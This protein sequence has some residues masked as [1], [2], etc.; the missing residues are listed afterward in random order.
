LLKKITGWKWR[1]TKK[2]SVPDGNE[3]S[4]KVIPSKSVRI[5]SK[6]IAPGFY[7]IN[8]W[9]VGKREDGIWYALAPGNSDTDLFAD[10]YKMA[11]EIVIKRIRGIKESCCGVVCDMEIITEEKLTKQWVAG[12]RKWWK[13]WVGDAK[14]ISKLR[15]KKNYNRVMKYLSSGESMINRLKDN[16][17]YK[18]GL[19]VSPGML[20][21]GN[22]E[23]DI[24]KFK[25]A[26]FTKPKID[27][28]YMFDDALKKI[29]DI[30]L[31]FKLWY[32]AVYDPK[33]MAYVG[34]GARARDTTGGKLTT[35]DQYIKHIPDAIR[36]LD[37]VVSG[38]I[39]RRLS[40][41]VSVDTDEFGHDDPSESEFFIGK[42]K[43]VVDP[44]KR[45]VQSIVKQGAYLIHPSY[46][47]RYVEQIQ[48]AK[49]MIDRAGFG[50]MWY[51]NMFIRSELSAR[52]GVRVGVGTYSEGAHYNIEKDHVV[53]FG[54]PN[55]K[56]HAII[57]HELGHRWYFKFMNKKER[58]GFDSY[59]GGYPVGKTIPAPVAVKPGKVRAVS[60]Y[61]G[62]VPYEDFAE[63]FMWYVLGRK[64]TRDQRERFKEFALKGGKIRR[65]EDIFNLRDQL[66]EG[67]SKF[68]PDRLVRGMQG[69]W[70][71]WRRKWKKMGLKETGR[72]YKDADTFERYGTKMFQEASQMFQKLDMHLRNEHGYWPPKYDD[73]PKRREEPDRR[74]MLTYELAE[75]NRYFSTGYIVPFRDIVNSVESGD[76]TIKQAGLKVWKEATDIHDYYVRDF[77]GGLKRSK[78]DPDKR[79]SF[80]RLD[81]KVDIGKVKFVF[82]F[83]TED[84]IIKRD[85]AF[86]KFKP[87]DVTKNIIRAAD[88]A[89]ALMKKSGFGFMWKG[90]VWV[91]P[92][93]A[94]YPDIFGRG[95][96]AAGENTVGWYSSKTDQIVLYPTAY[97]SDYYAP[98]SDQIAR[99]LVHE[100]AHRY[101]FKHLSSA[102]RAQF[103]KWFLSVDSVSS[104]GTSSPSEDF[105][106]AMAVYILY[107]QRMTDT[108]RQRL[109][110]IV[111]SGGK[112]VG[113]KEDVEMVEASPTPGWVKL[114]ARSKNVVG[115]N[116]NEAIAYNWI[117]HMDEVFSKREDGLVGKRVSDWDNAERCASCNRK[118]VHVYYVKTKDGKI[119]PYGGDHLH[120]ALG[121]PRE[122][123]K[124]KLKKI[125]NQVTSKKE[126]ERENRE[127]EQHYGKHIQARQSDSIAGANE[128]FNIGVNMG[129]LQRPPLGSKPVFLFNMKTRSVMRGDMLALE[130]FLQ[131]NPDWVVM[132]PGKIRSLLPESVRLIA[133]VKKL[134]DSILG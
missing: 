55:S 125:Q 57:I 30:K 26:A 53:L 97:H 25:K 108:Q 128:R 87:H 109:E 28:V 18:K 96:K 101:W 93:G 32:D 1:H 58:A 95:S 40:R 22:R 31:S 90:K 89:Q 78:Q 11:K 61:G 20:D 36:D 65:H 37:V 114:A 86:R 8:G 39:L 59:F 54:I 106:E 34:Y 80:G 19:M 118:I 98:R 123:S 6:R 129:K 117:S 50:K 15:G 81:Q 43:V 44:G 72:R 92:H 23:D 91:G 16:I 116:G 88:K 45:D 68:L 76:L 126:L 122:M 10:S 33:S 99:T 7:D 63:V 67:Q 82:Q 79:S 119:L 115:P 132:E 12:V 113:M 24:K 3:F 69:W 111:K 120:I 56:L 13:R 52:Q 77:I 35:Y 14:K 127:M 84:E 42:V 131:Y 5:V 110:Q 83:P 102:Q 73:W 17:E 71:S 103:E 104:Y 70:D 41:Y 100:I 134:R 51:G 27:L 60:S 2:S 64:L 121:Y 94:G 47:K 46:N 85:D 74:E 49:D 66:T 133:D 9:K 124:A 130:R 62:E 29:D 105:A 38:K 107:P 4:A 75:I 48:M 21:T 112:F